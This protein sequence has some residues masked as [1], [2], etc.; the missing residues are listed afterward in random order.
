MVA[1]KGTSEHGIHKISLGSIE[2]Y[3]KGEI[4]IVL[5]FSTNVLLLFFSRNR[6]S[7]HPDFELASFLQLKIYLQFEIFFF[8]FLF[9][10]DFFS[11][12]TIHM[13]E[14]AKIKTL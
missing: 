2:L 5:L 4:E 11:V 9:F 7:A 8:F 3:R 10:Y 12:S 1:G 6:P 14:M 13:F